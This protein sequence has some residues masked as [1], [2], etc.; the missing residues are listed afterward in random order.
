MI[1]P[2]DEPA[3]AGTLDGESTARESC[4][5]RIRKAPAEAGAGAACDR[6]GAVPAAAT[7]D[8]PLALGA[9]RRP[10]SDAACRRSGTVLA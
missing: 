3:M 2:P 10:R 6:R 9:A 1:G 7:I 5:L 8:A 4:A